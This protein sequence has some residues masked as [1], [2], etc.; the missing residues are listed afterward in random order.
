MNGEERTEKK[1]IHNS[2]EQFNSILCW[3]AP[4][5]LCLFIFF[6]LFSGLCICLSFAR[7]F[8]RRDWAVAAAA[9]TTTTTK[10]AMFPIINI[11]NWR[12]I[13]LSIYAFK[14]IVNTQLNNMNCRKS[15]VFF[16]LIQALP[17]ALALSLSRSLWPTSRLALYIATGCRFS[18]LSLLLTARL[19]HVNE[20]WW[21]NMQCRERHKH[22]ISTH[23]HTHRR[24][25]KRKRERE[26]VR[27]FGELREQQRETQTTN[28]CECGKND[29]KWHSRII[30]HIY[31]GTET[32]RHRHACGPRCAFAHCHYYTTDHTVETAR[33]GDDNDNDV[34][35]VQSHQYM[36]WVNNFNRSIAAWSN[37]FH[38]GLVDVNRSMRCVRCFSMYAQLHVAGWLWARAMTIKLK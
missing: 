33:Y 17:V 36:N 18:S 24:T 12:Y 31:P 34:P 25:T 28:T 15:T 7:R 27:L 3:S 1:K 11:F 35:E 32:Q 8:R 29:K 5:A 26:I 37:W 13:C 2:N 6:F 38:F 20:T 19:R 14:A 4:I 9:S 22:A 10:S 23:T 30:T 16:L 21:T